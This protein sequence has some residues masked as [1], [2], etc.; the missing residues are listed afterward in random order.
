[1][2]HIT[3]VCSLTLVALRCGKEMMI[4]WLSLLVIIM[5]LFLLKQV[6]LFGLNVTTSDALGIGY[7]LGLNLI[8]EFFG[9]KEARRAVW[10]SLF[11]ACSFLL[12]SSIHLIYLPN[13]YDSAHLHF[14]SILQPMPRI[15]FASL[16]SFLVIQWI[17]LAFFGFLKERFKGRYLTIRTTT[18]LFLS[19]IL[20]TL[21][22]SYLGLYGLV[23]SVPHIICLCLL[24]KGIVILFS[25]PFI[26]F[27][28]RIYHVNV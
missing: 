24:I 1:L 11:I 23:A 26:T 20:D 19:Q 9:R 13:K 14:Q 17:D 6:T 7:L 18:T 27:S 10:I 15:V 2:L 16:F 28:K 4:A 22:F 12:L 3:T 5:N 25:A 21:L 8:Q